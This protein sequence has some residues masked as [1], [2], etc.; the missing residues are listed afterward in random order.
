LV[1]GSPGALRAQ[2]IPGYP[3]NIDAFDRREVALLPQYCTYTQLFRG[4]VPGGSNPQMIDAWSAR[5]GPVFNHMHHYCFGLMNTHRALYLSRDATTRS[6][7]LNAAVREY[8]YVISRTT[9]AFVMLPE[10]FSKK[11]EALGHLGRGPLAVFEYERA[12]ELKPDYW[13]PYAHLADHYK[14]LGDLKKAREVLEAG[15]TKAPDAKA[16][17]RRLAELNAAGR[18]VAR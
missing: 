1:L 16:L 13:P 15:L 14:G 8:D 17:Q 3:Q 7:Y 4:S 9:E 11:G 10:I 18:S 5:M 2:E 6:F 12:I